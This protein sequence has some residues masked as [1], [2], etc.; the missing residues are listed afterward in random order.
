MT[1]EI[2]TERTDDGKWMFQVI[3]W[4]EDFEHDAE[5]YGYDTE[6]EANDAAVEVLISWGEI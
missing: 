4:D 3:S 6:A 5:G 1:N 2:F